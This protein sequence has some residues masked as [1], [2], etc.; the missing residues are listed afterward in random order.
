MD[1]EQMMMAAQFMQGEEDEDAE[2]K[3]LPSVDFPVSV[4]GMAESI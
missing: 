3:A 4:G 2:E 1:E